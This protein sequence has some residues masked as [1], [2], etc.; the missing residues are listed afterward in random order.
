MQASVVAGERG[1]VFSTL[2]SGRA[3]GRELR[4]N[5][6]VIGIGGGDGVS[7]LN[8]IFNG[9][10]SSLPEERS[11]RMRRVSQQSDSASRHARERNLLKHIARNHPFRIIHNI[12][13]F[14][15]LS[16]WVVS[17]A[18]Y[19]IYGVFG[20][21]APDGAVGVVALLGL[22]DADEPLTVVDARPSG[23]E[24]VVVEDPVSHA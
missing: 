6:F 2:H 15:V 8:G 16:E 1:N 12:T 4:G 10:A 21:S 9:L 23:E 17:V 11:H 18:V 3:V 14:H 7:K 19:I 5:V 22:L 20:C 24:T 13:D